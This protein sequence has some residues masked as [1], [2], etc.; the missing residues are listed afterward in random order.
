MQVFIIIGARGTG[1]STFAQDRLKSQLIN[2]PEIVH[3]Y[4]IEKKYYVPPRPLPDIDVFSEKVSNLKDSYIVYE[5]A[6][7]FFPNRGSNKEL[8]KALVQSRYNGNVI[9][10]IYH[11]ICAVPYYVYELTD[12]VILFKTQ[13]DENRVLKKFA[14]LHPAWW[15]LQ[16]V[17]HLCAQY[18]LRNGNYS[19]YLTIKL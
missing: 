8:K 18:K 13:D 4:D 9:F 1:K 14:K 10:M 12:C 17:P 16:K 6:T 7:I 2:S 5:E 11:S 19:P 15:K 3:V